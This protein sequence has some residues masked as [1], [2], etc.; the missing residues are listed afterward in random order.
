MAIISRL[1]VAQRLEP[2]GLRKTLIAVRRDDTF[3][4]SRIRQITPTVDLVSL[5]EFTSSDVPH[6]GR[7]GISDPAVDFPWHNSMA[8]YG[9]WFDRIGESKLKQQVYQN[10]PRI[11]HQKM[12][13]QIQRDNQYAVVGSYYSVFH[14]IIEAKGRVPLVLIDDTALPVLSFPVLLPAL[15]DAGFEQMLRELLKR[16]LRLYPSVARP[17]DIGSPDAHGIE[18]HET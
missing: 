12:L 14:M 3:T 9:K 11:S 10:V 5:G 1:S 4:V 17:R 2:L 15:T 8:F 6:I 16:M 13:E 7:V 18:V